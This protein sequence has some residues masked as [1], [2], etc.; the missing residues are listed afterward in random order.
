MFQSKSSLDFVSNESYLI[1]NSKYGLREMYMTSVKT[2]AKC[3]AAYNNFCKLAVCLS[4]GVKWLCYSC[5]IYVHKV[6][7]N[8][9]LF[10]KFFS[11]F[12]DY[13]V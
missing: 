1:K 9:I 11:I 4:V 5:Q 3:S 2:A 7:Q 10:L 13:K 12:R 6:S 8:Y